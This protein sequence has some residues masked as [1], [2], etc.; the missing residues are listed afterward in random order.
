MVGRLYAAGLDKFSRARR[1]GAK[2]TRS[3][4]LRLCVFGKEKLIHYPGIAAVDQLLQASWTAFRDRD[5]DLVDQ[6]L[7]VSR[8][9]N[10][11]EDSDRLRK[12]GRSMRA[13][14]NAT[15]G[16][17][18]KSRVQQIAFCDAILPMV[19][20]SGCAPFMRMPRLRSLPKIMVYRAR[21]KHAVRTNPAFRKISKAWSLKMLQ[22]W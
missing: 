19:T 18:G 17:L 4:P 16:S 20:T 2:E 14:M 7:F 9:L 22:F 10:R 1:K 8:P 5:V 3:L 15:D 21:G 6:H 12:S 11:A 13:S